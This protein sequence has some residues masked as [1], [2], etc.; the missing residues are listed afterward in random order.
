M[1]K[2]LYSLTVLGFTTFGCQKS[3][4]KEGIEKLQNQVMAVHDEVMPHQE[5]MMDLKEKISHQIDSLSK[6]TPST[7]ALK[8]RQ[9]EG[10]A[11][12][13]NLTEAVTM[14]DDWMN[15][16]KLDSVKTLDDTQAKA[17]LNSELEKITTVKTKINGG[18]TQAKTFLGN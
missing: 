6:I 17:Y 12:N 15:Q 4:D 9:E 3:G 13:K 10:I 8:T 7:P 18:I 1:K 2:V 5:L 16:F 14:M 11:A